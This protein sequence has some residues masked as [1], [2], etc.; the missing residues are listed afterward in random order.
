LGKGVADD[1]K[2]T[3]KRKNGLRIADFGFWIQDFRNVR[4]EAAIDVIAAQEVKA[5]TSKKILN[6]KS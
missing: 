3:C 2:N 6:R 5:K 4:R 1:K